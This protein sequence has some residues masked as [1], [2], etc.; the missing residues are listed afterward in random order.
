MKT[1]I[2]KLRGVSPYS[3]SKHYDKEQVP[4]LEKESHHAYEA[5]TWKN[6]LHINDSGKVFIPPMAFKNC[7]SEAAQFL[8]EK[9]PGKR[10]ATWTKHFLA[11]ILVSEPLILKIKRD[12]VGGEWF[13]VPSDGK[14]GGGSR[15]NKCFPV[16]K[17]WDG[18][19]L[20]Y[21]LDQTIT[22]DAFRH[23]LEEAGKFIGIGRFRPR[24][25]GFYGRFEVVNL[26][27]N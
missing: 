3:Q 15:V 4:M 26:K 11:G 10:N 22:E 16:I 9:I 14:R 8:G 18:D 13:F 5:R 20:F 25:G 7:I 6:R 24:N 27:W 12:E 17:D 1:V 19:V 21:I 23:H 2:A